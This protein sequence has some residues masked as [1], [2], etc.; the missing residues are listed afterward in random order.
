MSRLRSAAFICALA[1]QTAPALPSTLARIH[2]LRECFEWSTVLVITNDSTDATPDILRRWQASSEGVTVLC[3]DG[4]AASVTA[5]TDRLAAARNLGLYH[6]RQAIE[7]GR[8]IDIMVVIDTDGIN[9][10]LVTGDDFVKAIASA[11]QD[12]VAVFGNQRKAYYDIWALRHRKWCPSD[13]WQDVQRAAK[14]YP[15][16]FRGRAIAKAA[17]RFVG[18]RQVQISPENDPIPVESAFGG[19]G[20][21]RADALSGVW[22]SGRDE[23]GR[24]V[25]EHVSLNLRLREAGGKLYILPALLN[26]A[27]SEH[28]LEGSGATGSPWL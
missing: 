5:R 9:S 11:P 3:L 6:L 28:L 12:W 21:Y 2:E 23:A 17:K 25:C 26:D 19:I 24:E 1:R 7:S 10:Q 4:L 27:P 8:R 13:C 18:D 16:P 20:I 15:P 22:Y 14:R